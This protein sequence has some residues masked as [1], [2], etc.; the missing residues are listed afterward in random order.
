M[1]IIL[2]KDV[3]GL[4]KGGDVVKVADGYGRNYLLPKG[5]ALV[6]TPGNLR[7][8]EEQRRIESVRGRKLQREAEKLAHAL[9]AVSLTAVVKAGEDDRLFGS[10]T[11]KDIAALLEKEGYAVD[12][13]KIDLPEPIKELGVY[14]I[15]VN[16]HPDVPAKVKIWVVKE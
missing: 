11:S 9:D 3:E 6:S 15:P 14:Q 2:R 8:F 13:R 10:V 16:L 1:E 4:G 5:L 12:R 7:R